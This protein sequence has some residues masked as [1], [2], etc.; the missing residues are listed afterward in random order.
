MPDV[1][2]TRLIDGYTREGPL[3][4]QDVQALVEQT[5]EKKP[6]IWMPQAVSIKSYLTFCTQPERDYIPILCITGEGFHIVLTDHVGQIETDVIPFN[7]NSSTLIFFRMVMGLAFLPDSMMGLDTTIIRRELGVSSGKK[8]SDVYPPF[9]YEI[10][11]PS[12]QFLYPPS[13]QL[14][15]PPLAVTHDA[16]PADRDQEFGSISIGS[17][18]Y[19]I[20]KFLFRTQ[21]LIG[22]AT[23]TFLVQLPDGRRGVLKDSWITTDRMTEASFLQGLDIPFGLKLINHCVLGNTSSFRD[24]PIKMSLNKEVREKRRIVTYPAG[25]HISDFASLW[26]LMVAMLDVV[27]GMIDSGFFLAALLTLTSFLLFQP[28]CTSK[29]NESFIVTFHIQISYFGNRKMT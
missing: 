18:T 17:E 2:L 12:I 3:R 10:T 24:S 20:L 4:W 13:N 28:S 9:D 21:T 8:F 27:I 19:P 23:S 15:D 22:R 14:S 26:E 25:V 16:A 5:Q 1:M 6:P 7:R 29:V 11:R